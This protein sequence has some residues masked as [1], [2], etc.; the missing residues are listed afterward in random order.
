M[1]EVVG[2][3]LLAIRKRKHITLSKVAEDIGITT[4]KLSRMERNKMPITID[5]L[6]KLLNYY[7]VSYDI[8]FKMICDFGN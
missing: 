1:N 5:T 2:N 4:T 7:N 6:H 3:E 8:F